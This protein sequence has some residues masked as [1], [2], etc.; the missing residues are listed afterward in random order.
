MKNVCGTLLSVRDAVQF[1]VPLGTSMNDDE[2]LQDSTAVLFRKKA[3]R[4]HF[5]SKHY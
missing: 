3:T 1:V 5:L 4:R 2:R